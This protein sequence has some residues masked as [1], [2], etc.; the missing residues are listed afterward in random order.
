MKKELK[1]I[2]KE[3]KEKKNGNI[4]IKLQLQLTDNINYI[5]IEEKLFENYCK[6]INELINKII[7]SSSLSWTVINSAV[8]KI[9]NNKNA[10]NQQKLSDLLGN[11][12]FNEIF[13]RE[14]VG[15]ISMTFYYLNQILMVK[16]TIIM[17]IEYL[18]K[19]VKR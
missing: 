3:L 19:K 2:Q 5:D 6:Q 14:F 15:K 10:L 17:N 8:G 4:K 11:N 18:V 13:Y 7:S 16:I 12:R 9:K 1:S